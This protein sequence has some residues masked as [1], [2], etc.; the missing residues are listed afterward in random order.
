MMIK[1]LETTKLDVK[2]HYKSIYVLIFMSNKTENLENESQEWTLPVM[3]SANASE[4]GTEQGFD[5]S[6]TGA[7][8]SFAIGAVTRSKQQERNGM[9]DSSDSG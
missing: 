7:W 9:R 4:N 3:E 2:K 8:T 6:K 5:T 1:T